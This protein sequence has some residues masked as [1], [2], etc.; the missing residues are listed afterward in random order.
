MTGAY[1]ENPLSEL[2]S[3]SWRIFGFLIPGFIVA[4]VESL[5]PAWRVEAIYIHGKFRKEIET[6]VVKHKASE[7]LKFVDVA[8]APQDICFP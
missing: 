4:L 6:R 7:A 2:W 1:I 8:L 3:I 5:P